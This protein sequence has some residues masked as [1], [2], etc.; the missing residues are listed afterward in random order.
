MD[1]A[2][3]DDGSTPCCMAAQNGH[4]EVV[5]ALVEAEAVVDKARVDDGTTPCLIA[6]HY[7]HAE[8]ARALIEAGADVDK[9]RTDDGATPCLIAA[10][11]GYAEVAR[12]LIEAGADVHVA[13]ANGSTP[14]SLAA[15]SLRNFLRSA[16]MLNPPTIPLCEWIEAKPFTQLRRVVNNAHVDC[17]VCFEPFNKGARTKIMTVCCGYSM[18]RNCVNII[19]HKRGRFSCPQCRKVE[20]SNDKIGMVNLVNVKEWMQGRPTEG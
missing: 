15:P 17:P 7:G 16:A 2:T 9:A 4:V 3:A 8:V 11:N 20:G 18:C 12:A 14:V 1:A 13:M 5:R 10:Q 6:A 19:R